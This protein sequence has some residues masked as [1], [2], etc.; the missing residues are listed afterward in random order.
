MAHTHHGIATHKGPLTAKD[1]SRIA[2]SLSIAEI[3]LDSC[4]LKFAGYYERRDAKSIP[5]WMKRRVRIAL[6]MI[7]RCQYFFP[8]QDYSLFR[9]MLDHESPDQHEQRF[10]WHK[11]KR[12]LA[13][14]GQKHLL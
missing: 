8:Q 9:W 1:L 12:G 14:R 11:Y 5:L 13:A 3:A 6:G 4:Q 2:Q 7:R 10:N